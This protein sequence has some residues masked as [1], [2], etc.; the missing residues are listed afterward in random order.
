[1]EIKMQDVK[2]AIFFNSF[3][4]EYKEVQGGGHYLTLRG[5]DYINDASPKRGPVDG[6]GTR[7]GAKGAC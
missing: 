4:S 6:V 2:I 7:E 5:L 1:M 3:I